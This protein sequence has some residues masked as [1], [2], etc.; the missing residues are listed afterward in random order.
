[1]KATIITLYDPLPNIGN[2]LQNYA[3]QEVLTQFGFKTDTIS[4]E[5]PLLS[6]KQVLKEILQRISGYRIWG[7]E[8]YW[9]NVPRRI[10]AF[11]SFNQ[12]YIKT[13]H[14]QNIGQ[15]KYADY[16]VLGSDQVWNPFWYSDLPIKRELFF[17]TFAESKQKVCFAPSFGIEKLPDEW[18][19]WFAENLASFPMISVREEAGAEIIRELTGIDPFVMIDPTLMLDAQRWNKL[20]TK[21]KRIDS[22]KTYILTYFL[23]GRSDKLQLDIENYAKSLNAVVYNLLDYEQPELYCTSPSDFLY[24]I[25]HAK[26]I[27]TDSFHGCVFSLLY[28]KPFLV[29]KRDGKLDMMSRIETFLKR[30]DLQRKYI[31]SGIANQLLECDYEAGYKT[32]E[33]ERKKTLDFLKI[34]MHIGSNEER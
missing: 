29:Y 14:I 33:E 13:Q 32:L 8:Q 30:F 11:E 26:L 1:M 24:L 10:R 15:I 16:F 2:R 6:S 21:P 31:E 12:K 7:D 23:G 28:G 3:V 5:K 27:L 9:K 20:A 34:S 25:S 18:K 4:Y 17:L 22:D 19:L